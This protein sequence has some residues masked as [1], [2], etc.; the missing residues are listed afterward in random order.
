MGKSKTFWVI[1]LSVGLIGL[2]SGSSLL[3][4]HPGGGGHDEHD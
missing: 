4:A 3:M 2:M 1:L